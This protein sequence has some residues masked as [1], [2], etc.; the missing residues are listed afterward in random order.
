HR[1]RQ[2]AAASNERP[3]LETKRAMNI[4]E[5]PPALAR[6][7]AL[8]SS[9]PLRQARVFRLQMALQHRQHARH[10]GQHRNAL[11]LYRLD[12]PRR[13]EPALEVN[14]RSKDRRNPKSHRLPKD[15][16]QRQRVEKT[17]RMNQPFVAHVAT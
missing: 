5:A 3:E 8:C 4:A 15:M 7:D 9:Q 10:S 1:T 17:Q 2:C 6:R 12:E 11:T 14:L 16:A 13:C